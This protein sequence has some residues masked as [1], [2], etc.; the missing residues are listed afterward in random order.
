MALSLYIVIHI[1][2][3]TLPTLTTSEGGEQWNHV[4]R[5]KIFSSVESVRSCVVYSFERG[6]IW[7]RNTASVSFPPTIITTTT[8]SPVSYIQYLRLALCCNSRAIEHCVCQ[9]LSIIHSSESFASRAHLP[10]FASLHSL[11]SS[12]QT[13]CVCSSKIYTHTH[14]ADHHVSFAAKV[15]LSSYREDDARGEEVSAGECRQLGS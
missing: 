9:C 5:V 6:G 7:R 8:T 13:R 4:T 10:R 1:H 2:R 15:G 12:C 11:H 14:E 3:H